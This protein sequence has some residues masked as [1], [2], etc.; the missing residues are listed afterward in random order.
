[1]DII[2]PSQNRGCSSVVERLVAN[3]NVEGSSPFTRSSL[4]LKQGGKGRLERCAEALREGGPSRRF[5][6]RL[7][8]QP[9][10]V[11]ALRLSLEIRISSD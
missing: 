9:L 11:D 4:R 10:K 8:S 2:L 5:K 3:E 7:A 6:L 1:M